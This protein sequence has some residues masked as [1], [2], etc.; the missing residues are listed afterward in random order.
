MVA[1]SA[2]DRAFYEKEG[3]LVVRGCWPADEASHWRAR[4]LE[5]LGHGEIPP[6]ALNGASGT[7]AQVLQVQTGDAVTRRRSERNTGAVVFNDRAQGLDPDN[8][9]GLEFVQGINLLGDEWLAHVVDPRL[10]APV[11]GVLGSGNLNLHHHKCS[12]KP[13]RFEGGHGGGGACS[14]FI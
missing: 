7:H 12:L 3:Y 4:L 6:G 13:P 8:P 10:V 1:T 5:A 11:A 9:A 2:I 14:P